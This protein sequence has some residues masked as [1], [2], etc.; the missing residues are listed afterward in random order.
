MTVL[1]T[2]GAGYIGSH[3]VRLLRERG[4]DVVVYDSMEYGHRDAVLGA[5]L[6]VGPIDDRELVAKTVAEHGIESVIHFAAYKAAGESMEQP[7]RYFANNVGATNVLLDTLQGAGVDKFVFSSTCAVYGTPTRLPV[8]EDHPLG[9]ESP[10]G[11]SKRMVEQ[12]LA[13]YDACH[14]LRSVSLRYFNAAGAAADG[15]IGEDWTYTLNLV[16]LVMKA[17]LGRTDAIEVFG[18]DYP[19]PDGTCIRDYVHVE[20]LADAHIRAL[21]YLESGEKSTVINLGTGKGSSVR[22]V[23]DA[24][25]DASGVDIPSRDTDRRKGDPVAIYGDNRKAAD[26]LGW[27]PDR[28]LTTIVASAWQWHSTHPDGYDH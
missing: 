5:P 24:A 18:T 12:M 13:W 1:V 8:D 9:P 20:D 7:G 25:R 28:N 6:V 10:Y 23:I 15:R 27:R 3:T 19:T 26:L 17:A 2:G 14:G 16:P 11:E 21:D 4:R 22:E